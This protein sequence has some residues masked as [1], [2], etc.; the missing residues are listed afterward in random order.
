MEKCSSDTD[1]FAPVQLHLLRCGSTG[2]TWALKVDQGPT[3]TH[4]TQP[5]KWGVRQ[6]NLDVSTVNL[7]ELQFFSSHFFIERLWQLHCL[8][9]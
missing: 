6:Q 4:T 1:L 8:Q 7:E 9:K 5:S 3:A 2:E